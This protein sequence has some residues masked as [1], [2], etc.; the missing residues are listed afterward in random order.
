MAFFDR[1]TGGLVTSTLPLV[2]AG[3]LGYSKEQRGW[4]VGLPLILMALCT[5]PAGA[6]CD[7]LGS[8]R[9]RLAAGIAYAI[10]FAAIPFAGGNQ[11]AMAAVLVPMGIAMGALF[12]SSLALAAESGGGAVSIGSFRAAGDVGSFAGTAV[13]VLAVQ[14]I[15]AGR[16]AAYG[17]YATIIVAF[18]AAHLACTAAIGM[19]AAR[20]VSS[21]R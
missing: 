6:V 19:L 11:P 4:L 14:A 2:L 3:F 1:A 10:A 13:S 21:R 7:R 16:E 5:G 17:D 15:A 8:L 12:S 9:V 20:G 18:A